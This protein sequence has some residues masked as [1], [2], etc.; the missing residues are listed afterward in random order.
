[1]ADAGA[2]NAHYAATP[3]EA[4]GI[5]TE[6]FEGLASIVAQNLSVELRPTQ[7]VKVLG[8]LND[9]QQLPVPGGVQM[10]L[11]D[12]YGQ[13]R[14]RIVFELFV[15]RLEELGVATV[16]QVVVRY[17]SVGAQVAA[18]K[19]T[20]PVTVNLVSADETA[21]AQAD[22][23]VIEEVVI[24]RSARAQ[25]E[26]RERAQTGDLDGAKGLLRQAAGDLRKAAPGSPRAAELEQQADEMGEHLRSLDAGSF[27]A[28]TSKRMKFQS[29]THH[30][31]RREP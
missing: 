1:M 7:E 15:P 13:E 22:H 29:R 12:A 24:L 31:K 28:A 25:E 23:E 4:P 16:A 14:R 27:D 19:L 8:V 26:A 18:N 2:G 10:Q 30:R 9:Y 11:G 17:V 3:E 20:M 5:F 6:E 21:A